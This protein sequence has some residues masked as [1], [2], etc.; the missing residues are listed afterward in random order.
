MCSGGSTKDDEGGRKSLSDNL[1]ELLKYLDFNR[2]L[3]AK[4]FYVLIQASS[5]NFCSVVEYRY[6][7]F[8]VIRIISR[9]M[10]ILIR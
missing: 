7:K 5:S 3:Y 1:M 10:V 2:L 4:Y 9:V 6:L 8:R